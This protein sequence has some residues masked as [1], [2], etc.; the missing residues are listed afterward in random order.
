MAESVLNFSPEVKKFVEDAMN[1][2]NGKIP[3]NPGFVDDQYARSEFFQ[4]RRACAVS[5][6]G[7]VPPNLDAGQV[8]NLVLVKATEEAQKGTPVTDPKHLLGFHYFIMQDKGYTKGADAGRKPEDAAALGAAAYATHANRNESTSP[9]V[10]FVINDPKFL[11]KNATKAVG[12]NNFKGMAFDSAFTDG[13]NHFLRTAR[14]NLALFATVPGFDEQ[15]SK[16]AT[17]CRMGDPAI[18]LDICRDAGYMLG[19]KLISRIEDK[20]HTR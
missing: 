1:N 17:A 3:L 11:P 16:P 10:E 19:Q 7:V 8:C 15:I 5:T 9:K 18:T 20:S 14:R 2:R 6:V 4:L 13:L 12:F